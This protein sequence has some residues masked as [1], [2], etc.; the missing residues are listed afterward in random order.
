MKIEM[1]TKTI[2]VLN[3]IIVSLLVAA[4]AHPQE[5]IMDASSNE[6]SEATRSLAS[7]SNKCDVKKEN[8]AMDY[9]TL[10]FPRKGQFWVESH[11][12]TTEDIFDGR[13][14]FPAHQTEK[15]TTH[16]NRSCG[17]LKKYFPN[18]SANCQ[19]VYKLKWNKVWTP[20]ENGKAGQGSVAALKPTPIQEMWLGNMKWSKASKPKPGEK[21][22][23]KYNN[24]AIV[25]AMGF[26]TGPGNKKV[27]G[28]LQPEGQ[29]ALGS[30]NKSMVEVGRLIDQSVPYG[31]IKC[32]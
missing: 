20:P 8:V 6:Q 32:N 17:L 16:M 7:D 27:L 13:R 30:T 28:G 23:L 14:L 12:A 25:V 4:C 31:P 26:E 3:T 19:E 9:G 22:L 21:W 10:S 18:L 5:E 24:K 1:T 15:I 11:L 29:F 2:T